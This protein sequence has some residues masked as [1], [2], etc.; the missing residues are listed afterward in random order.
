[1]SHLDYNGAGVSSTPLR[2]TILFDGG[3]LHVKNLRGRVA[4][5]T[6]ASMGIGEAIARC[7]ATEGCHVVPNSG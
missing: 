1:M 4:I 6:G 2:S 5:V 3:N 7:L